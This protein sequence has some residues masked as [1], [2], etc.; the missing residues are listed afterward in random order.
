VVQGVGNLRHA[1][2]L[3]FFLS[4]IIDAVVSGTRGELLPVLV[5]HLNNIS[6]LA[7]L[8]EAMYVVVN[9]ATGDQMHADAILADA[10]LM[11]AVERCLVCHDNQLDHIQAV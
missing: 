4:Q 6:N 10:E 7:T 3:T 9:M 1:S 5:A 8:T 11:R 2:A